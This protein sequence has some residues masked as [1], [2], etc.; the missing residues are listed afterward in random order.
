MVPAT[1]MRESSVQIIFLYLIFI[2]VHQRTMFL[3]IDYYRRSRFLAVSFH[4]L[5]AHLQVYA[6]KLH[7]G[8]SS[9]TIF[10]FQIFG[11]K[12]LETKEFITSQRNNSLFQF[13]GSISKK[14]YEALTSNY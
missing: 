6:K 5:K 8:L 9:K 2:T 4:F 13:L 3:W 11:S 14:L 10:N 12:Q 7:S 1:R